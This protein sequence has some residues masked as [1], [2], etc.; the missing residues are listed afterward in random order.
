MI[1]CNALFAELQRAARDPAEARGATASRLCLTA[2]P[3]RDER[4]AASAAVKTQL[5]SR[6]RELDWIKV[7]FHWSS[8]QQRAVWFGFWE[9]AGPRS[10][11]SWEVHEVVRVTLQAAL[12]SERNTLRC[13]RFPVRFHSVC[14]KLEDMACTAEQHRQYA[15]DGYVLLDGLFS[16]AEME[17][18]RREYDAMFA[19]AQR[20]GD[21]L[22][23]T[24]KGKW[25]DDDKAAQ[26]TSVLSIHNVQYHSAI[27]LRL[28]LNEKLGAALEELM[29]TPN[30]QLHHTKAHV[31]P[32]GKGSPFP[33][34]QDYQYFPHEQHSMIAAML[35]LE[36]AKEE[37]GCMCVYPG[38][39]KLGPQPDLGDGKYHFVDPE[40]FP[41]EKATAVPAKSGQVLVFPYFLVHGSYPNTSATPRR[42]LLFQLRDAGD[43]ASSA[44]HLSPGQGLM[45]RG[46]NPNVDADIN[47]RH[48]SGSTANGDGAE[49]PSKKAKTD[50]SA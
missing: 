1:T 33:M 37:N 9:T 4:P 50:D 17:E 28:L 7:V 43:E 42:M 8:V 29:G 32:P 44:I 38:S 19:R 20:R 25:R 12:W 26:N 21:T 35:H 16:E 30:I 41:I 47:R 48:K 11:T 5:V 49:P 13:E 23:A 18:C 31:K 22:E 34:H 6:S 36:D 24:W 10:R 45:V 39:H 46:V 14:E 40:K 15:D 3:D 27:F 2:M